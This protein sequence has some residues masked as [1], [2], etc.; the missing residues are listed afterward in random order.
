MSR[1]EAWLSAGCR[2]RDGAARARLGRDA[3]L[4]SR[5]PRTP[6]TTSAWRATWSTA[7]ASSPTRSGASG[8]RRSSFPRPAFEVWLPLPSLLAA[9][10]MALFGT[11]FAAAQVR[12]SSSGRSS[13]SSPGG[14]PPTSRRRAG[15]RPARANARPRRGPHRGGLPA[16]RPRLGPARLDH[17][18][19]GVRPRGVPPDDPPDTHGG[20]D[21]R[22]SAAGCRA[23]RTHERARRARGSFSGSPR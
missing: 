14:S 16:A 1:R 7:A 12:R 18:V 15:S 8:R 4:P 19:C 6:P 20:G 11:T 3:V 5:G 23:T 9:I 13:R 2:L 10:P 17:A 22:R 21:R